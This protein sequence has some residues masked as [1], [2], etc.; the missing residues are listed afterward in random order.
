ML[1]ITKLHPRMHQNSPKISCMS[2]NFLGEHAPKPPKKDLL[3]SDPTLPGLLLS[4]L[5]T[6]LFTNYYLQSVLIMVQMTCKHNISIN[7][8]APPNF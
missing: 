6:T 2:K 7:A 3:N 1:T 4:S 8:F 5:S